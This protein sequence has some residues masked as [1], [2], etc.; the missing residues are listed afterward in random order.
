MDAETMERISEAAQSKLVSQL[1]VDFRHLFLSVS[2]GKKV[3]SD[4]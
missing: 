4:N 2:D 3:E 1:H